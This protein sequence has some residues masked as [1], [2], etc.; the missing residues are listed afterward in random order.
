MKFNF[1]WYKN[2]QLCLQIVKFYNYYPKKWFYR[3]GNQ[4]LGETF[5]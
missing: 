4:N 1:R 5:A 2:F 3:K